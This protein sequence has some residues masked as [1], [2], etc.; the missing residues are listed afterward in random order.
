L[1]VN[2]LAKLRDPLEKKKEVDLKW[3]WVS[4]PKYVWLPARFLSKEGG[5]VYYLTAD[6]TSIKRPEAAEKSAIPLDRFLLTQTTH[7]LITIEGGRSEAYTLYTLANRYYKN[8]IYT[9]VSDNVLLSINPYKNLPIYSDDI[10][11]LYNN[12]LGYN[13]PPHIYK[14]ARTTVETL[15]RHGKSQSIIIAGESGSGKTETC[16]EFIKV[17][18]KKQ[19]Y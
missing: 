1:E 3:F 4:D 12:P 2:P 15:I 13:L 16:K 8:K 7:D 6:N 9:N 14:H 19:I 18:I 10:I 5:F 17:L 11:Q